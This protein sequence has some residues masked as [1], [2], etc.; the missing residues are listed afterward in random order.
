MTRN[1]LLSALVAVAM[2]H[3]AAFAGQSP[4]AKP[5]LSPGESDSSS[6]TFTEVMT[7]MRDGV[8]LQT[9][10]LAPRD[11]GEPLPIL[12]RRSPYGVPAKAFTAIPDNLKALAADK[13]IFVIQNLRGRFKSEGTFGLSEDT[14]VTP[15]EGTIETRDGW[16]TVDWLVKKRTEQQWPGGHLR[17][18]L[19]WIHGSRHLARTPS[20][21]E[22]GQ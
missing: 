11:A 7:P 19:R 14:R 16:D 18:F 9:V 2:C 22:G 20:G 10:I 15:G 3:P 13:Y 4:E 1:F 8:R 5:P 12:L 6:Y 21:V 17:G